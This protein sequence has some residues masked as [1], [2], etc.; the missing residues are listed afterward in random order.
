[1]RSNKIKGSYA[2]EKPKF[3][4]PEHHYS[5][6]EN[7]GN[8]LLHNDNSAALGSRQGSSPQLN[9][10]SNQPN[11]AQFI[12]GNSESNYR[13]LHHNSSMS[14][15]GGLTKASSQ[16]GF[17]IVIKPNSNTLNQSMAPAIPFSNFNNIGSSQQPTHML[18]NHSQPY[19]PI[20]PI[21][22]QNFYPLPSSPHNSPRIAQNSLNYNTSYK[23]GVFP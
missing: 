6:F 11:T 22:Q 15:L 21:Y 8:N 23:N 1:M 9:E 4:N 19:F 20:Q 17:T 5:N 2:S 16:R 10:I 3:N 13:S 14:H 7:S 12:H 18:K